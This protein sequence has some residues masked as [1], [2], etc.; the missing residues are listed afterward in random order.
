MKQYFAKYLPVDEEIQE[1]EQ[2]HL[3][4]ENDILGEDGNVVTKVLTN[5]RLSFLYKEGED[6]HFCVKKLH[7]CGRSGIT[8]KRED[9]VKVKLFLCSRDIQEGDIVGGKWLQGDKIVEFY[10]EKYGEVVGWVRGSLYKAIGEISPQAIWVKE[11]MEFDKE[12]IK[13]IL[14]HTS[15]GR[16]VVVDYKEWLE[17]DA[18]YWRKNVLIECPT[19]KQF[20]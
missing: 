13:F 6:Y 20:H 4:E 5:D 16:S 15:V 8:L 18:K 10:N 7:G 12:Q 3:V 11:E 1:F 2:A 9:F 17:V 14:H 19:C